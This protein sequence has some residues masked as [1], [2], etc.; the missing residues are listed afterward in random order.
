MC[1]GEG[2]GVSACSVVV[3]GGLGG[4]GRGRGCQHN[5][6]TPDQRGR[7]CAAHAETLSVYSKMVLW[8]TEGLHIAKGGGVALEGTGVM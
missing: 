6:F 8:M 1:T 3:V 7:A 4:R 5:S 2:G